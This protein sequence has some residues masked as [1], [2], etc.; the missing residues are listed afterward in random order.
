[1]KSTFFLK[2]VGAKIRVA[3][4]TKGLSQEKLAEIAG[5]HPT[6]ISDIEL[7]KVNGNIFSYYSISTAL[8]VPFSDLVDMPS[9]KIDKDL[10]SQLSEISSLLR[11]LD[12]SK[13]RIT[14]SA[15]KGLILG[16]EKV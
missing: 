4:K 10:E 1:M 7:G 11:R 3:R 5:L 9:G 14:L 16:V 12:R 15:V 13:Q 8:D 2:A 6:Y